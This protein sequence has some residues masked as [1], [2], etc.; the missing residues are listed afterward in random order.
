MNGS[1]KFFFML[2]SIVHNGV[3]GVTSD[4]KKQVA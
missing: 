3:Q 4:K 1:N 2:S